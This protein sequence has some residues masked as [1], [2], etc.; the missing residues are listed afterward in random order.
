M[1]LEMPLTAESV[2]GVQ[3]AESAGVLEQYCDH[4]DSLGAGRADA[5]AVVVGTHFSP[6][7][8]IPQT[9]FQGGI[10]RAGEQLVV[11]AGGCLKLLGS[12]MKGAGQE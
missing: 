2:P 12:K 3:R 7:K 10:Y 4:F 6:S 5:A 1:I 8:K 9:K 11:F